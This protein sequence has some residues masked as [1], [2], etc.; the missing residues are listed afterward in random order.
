MTDKENTIKLSGGDSY[1]T[2]NPSDCYRVISGT[3]IVYIAPIKDRETQRRSYLCEMNEGETI[4]A[5]YYRDMDY[6]SFCFVLAAMEEAE[7]EVMKDS[8]TKPL[9]KKFLLKA[10]VTGYEQD[11]FEDSLVNRYR[12][13]LVKEDGY[14]LRTSKEKEKVKD[15]IDGLISSVIDKEDSPRQGEKVTG[16]YQ[17]MSVLCK[18][19][20]IKIA[21]YSKVKA[22]C[23]RELSVEDIARVSHFPYRRLTLENNWYKKELGYMLVYLGKEAEPAALI[24]RGRR[25][26]Y[27]I[28]EGKKPEKLTKDVAAECLPEAYVIYRPFPSGGADRKALTEFVIKSIQKRDIIAAAVLTVISSLIGLLIPTLNQRLYDQYIPEGDKSL[29]LKVGVLIIAFMLGNICFSV[30]KSLCTFRLFNRVKYEVQAAMFYR[31]FELPQDFLNK[32]ESA[33]L[34]ERIMEL[35]L[36]AERVVNLAVTLSFSAVMMLFYLV[37]MLT[38]SV[39]LTV[40]SLIVEIIM[41]VL[42]CILA[43]RRAKNQ[44]EISRLRGRSQ[45]VMFQLISGIDKI[46]VSGIEDRALYEYM[47]PFTREQE[48]SRENTILDRKTTLLSMAGGNLVTL[49]MYLI[50]YNQTEISMGQ[51]VAFASAFGVVAGGINEVANGIVSMKLI[52][53]VYERVREIIEEPPEINEAK[54]LPQ[55]ITGDIKIDHVTFSYGE[56]LPRIMDDL[57]L[58]IKSGEYVGIVG[59]SGCGK[60]TLLKLLL[61]F[62]KPNQGSIYYDN[63]DMTSLDIRELRKKFGVVLQKGELITGTILE[64]IT[65]TAKSA[66]INDVIQV[67]QAVGLAEDIARMPMNLNTV[68]S[69]N[70]STISGGQKQ[71]ILIARALMNNPRI[72]LFDEATSALDNVTQHMVGEVLDAMGATRIVIA[73]RL[74]TIKSCDRIIVLDKGKIAEEGSYEEL[75]KKQG[76]FFK[77]ASRQIFL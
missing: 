22:C 65:L 5:F 31:V 14:I 7:L 43:G 45:S 27:I 15:D 42:I 67:V 23:G 2:E 76:M 26:Y 48:L 60:S 4:P 49:L 25:G 77:L 71:R 63:Q 28:R 1:V 40:I 41:A 47:K 44:A 57:S 36:I 53:P 58:H 16:L 9:K 75:M 70:S 56:N 17:V 21:D 61:G 62:I 33:D 38:Y 72:L 13:N 35:G 29:I 10:E 8:S 6:E 11:G 3:V 51:Y 64:N 12:M 20:G 30:I 73:H 34:G 68:V 39:K 66:D 37:R 55:E 69:E 74:S 50:T 24:P 54:K 19:A 52:K 59:T 46:R 32:Y 18:K